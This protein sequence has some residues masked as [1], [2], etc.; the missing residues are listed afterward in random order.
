MKSEVP[1][2]HDV[3][4]DHESNDSKGALHEAMLYDKS[5]EF[6]DLDNYKVTEQA[7]SDNLTAFQEV[8]TSLHSLELEITEYT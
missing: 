6:P 1:E 2:C 3:E 5:N 7:H 4:D 8:N